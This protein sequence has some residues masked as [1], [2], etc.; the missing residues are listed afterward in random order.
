MKQSCTH[1]GSKPK[2][3]K[4]VTRRQALSMMGTAGLFYAL[5]NPLKVLFNGLTDGL[6]ASAQAQSAAPTRN[7]VCILHS[8]A[9]T[10]WVWDGFLQPN[11]ASDAFIRNGSVNNWLTENHY[12]G[13]NA[14]TTYRSELIDLGDG[15]SIYLPALWAA[16]IPVVGGGSVPMKDLLNNTLMMRGIHMQFDIGHK[17]G[18]TLIPR[19]NRSGPSISGMV[20]DR[21]PTPIQAVG[22]SY[23]NDNL[24]D[25]STGAYQSLQGT[26]V[27]LVRGIQDPLNSLMSS[28]QN[29][30]PKVLSQAPKRQSLDALINSALSDLAAYARTSKPGADVLFR[31]RAKAEE[32]F[33]TGFGDLRTIYTELHNKYRELE[34]RAAQEPVANILPPAGIAPYNIASNNIRT[35]LAGQFAVA[36]FLLK[37]GLSSTITMGGSSPSVAGLSNFNDEHDGFDRQKSLIC[38]SFQFRALAAMLY[39]FRRSLGPA[40]WEQTVVEV[41]A[42]FERAP[43]NTGLGSDHAPDAN[44]VTVM[45]G[46]IK[47]PMFMGNINVVG[48]AEPYTGTFGIAAP[49]QTDF[50]SALL[51]TNEHVA[52][53]VSAIVGCESPVRAPSLVTVSDSGVTSLV[54]DPKNVA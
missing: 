12:T 1:K 4:T 31:T 7:Y 32:L 40:L 35:D 39:E 27:T 19:P 6:I 2:K 50:S 53:T 11:G 18:P 24:C 22:T 10:R 23:F 20:A 34:R 45:S 36:E 47:K 48:R 49:T 38:H 46:A 41:G 43:Q 13:D 5:D 21:A 3:R 14:K 17:F 42:E 52:S 29:V 44:S 26:G 25:P 16:T 30:D 37:S 8:G 15:R 9:P 54:E 28:F 33:R 51:V